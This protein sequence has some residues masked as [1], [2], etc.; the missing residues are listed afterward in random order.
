MYFESFYPGLSTITPQRTVTASELDAFLDLAGLHL[1]MF[2]DDDAARELGHPR[3]IVT[4]PMILAVGMGLVHACG[5]FDQVVGVLEFNDMRF[6]KAV[7]PGDT[8]QACVTVI[9]TRTTR[10][11]S[12][13]IVV[14][15][16]GITNQ[17]A[18][19]V[20]EMQGTYLVRRLGEDV[21]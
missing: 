7:H 20:V 21:G 6:K 19:A 1:P 11:P 14:L 13:G 12:R 5:W 8:L 4:G 16:Y 17:D 15:S 18:V 9:E 3:R 2:L 10:D